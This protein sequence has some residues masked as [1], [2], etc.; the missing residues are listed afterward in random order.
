MI[1]YIE[2]PGRHR[3]AFYHGLSVT[4]AAGL[5]ALAAGGPVLAADPKPG[6]PRKADPSAPFIAPAPA[7]PAAKDPSPQPESLAA[8]AY[9]PK[10]G[11]IL[12]SNPMEALASMAESLEK[13]ADVVAIEID[14]RAITQGEAADV[15]RA[16]PPTMA[17]QGF[18]GVYRRALDELF[19]QKVMVIAAEKMGLDKDAGVRRRARAASERALAEEFLSRATA[20]AVTEDMVRA[21]Y[22]RDIAGKPGPEEVRARLI[23]LPTGNEAR[24]VISQILAGAD[25]AELARNRSKDASAQ[26]GG[27]LGYVQLEALTPEIG[28]VLFTLTPGQISSSPIHTQLG[29]FV[30]RVEGRRQRTTPGY[31]EVHGRLVNEL[32]R[33]AVVP[34]IRAQ[35]S[36]AQVRQT[37]AGEKPPA[38]DLNGIVKPPGR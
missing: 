34:V 21:R 6:E 36:G 23:M 24:T 30:V 35:I 25:F 1:D 38:P 18:D 16:M 32:R 15:I 28:S 17:V 5:I 8:P 9:G 31:D 29:Y 12:L 2:V 27:D 37:P 19:R 14:G 26:A 10:T 22:D 7:A 20:A 33:E 13:R 11:P 4:M 3:R